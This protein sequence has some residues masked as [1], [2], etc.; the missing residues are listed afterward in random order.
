[1]AAVSTVTI[2]E[3]HKFGEELA[4]VVGGEDVIGLIVAWSDEELT[5]E[6]GVM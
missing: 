3:E 5:S 2:R 1:M 6:V 4:A